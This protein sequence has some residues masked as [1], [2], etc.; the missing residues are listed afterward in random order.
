MNKIN[1]SRISGC[2]LLA[3][4]LSPALALAGVVGSGTV[5]G[6]NW[7]GKGSIKDFSVANGD[8]VSGGHGAY[9]PSQATRWVKAGEKYN[10]IMVTRPESKGQ[11]FIVFT[12]TGK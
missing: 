9:T 12:G 3:L 7:P 5:T 8:A 10:L 2:L 6:V 11:L 4:L 1:V